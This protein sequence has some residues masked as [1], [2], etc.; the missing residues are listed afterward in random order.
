M[1]ALVELVT[2]IRVL[3]GA[4]VEES[5]IDFHEELH[6]VIDHAVDCAEFMYELYCDV[7]TRAVNGVGIDLPIPVTF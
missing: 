3:L 5:G 4:V 1:L 2:V 7:F 6:G